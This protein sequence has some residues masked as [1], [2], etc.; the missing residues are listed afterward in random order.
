MDTELVRWESALMGVHNL[1]LPVC[2]LPVV[3]SFTIN[4][5]EDDLQCTTL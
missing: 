3:V 5:S 4:R 2:G 1:L